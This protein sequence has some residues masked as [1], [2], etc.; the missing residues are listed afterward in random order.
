[1]PISIKPFALQGEITVVGIAVNI[2]KF[3]I[4]LIYT[5]LV[6]DTIPVYHTQFIPEPIQIIK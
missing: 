6:R 4:G 1:M 5:L 3:F 2:P